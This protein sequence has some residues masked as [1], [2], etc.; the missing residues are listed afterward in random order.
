[1]CKPKEDA[2]ESRN[3]FQLVQ[4]RVLVVPSLEDW[5]LYWVILI[6]AI[7]VVPLVCTAGTGLISGITLR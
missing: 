7:E 3:V 2:S 1:M 6:V 5:I 4:D